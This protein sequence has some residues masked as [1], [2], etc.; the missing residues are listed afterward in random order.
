MIGVLVFYNK[1]LFRLLARILF[2]EVTDNNI[3]FTA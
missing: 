2:H 1:T 3:N